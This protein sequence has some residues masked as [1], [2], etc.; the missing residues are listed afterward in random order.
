MHCIDDMK[1][2]AGR[3]CADLEAQADRLEGIA[4][5]V[6]SGAYEPAD[7]LSDQERAELV[8][9]L[10]QEIGRLR[11]ASIIASGAIGP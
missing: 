9:T 3:H 10:Y 6:A 11:A 7:Q 5:G 1:V 2:A 8:Q 4:K